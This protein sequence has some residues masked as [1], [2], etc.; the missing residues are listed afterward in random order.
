MFARVVF[1]YHITYGDKNFYYTNANKN[2][3]FNNTL[4]LAIPIQH[5]DM[6]N[7]SDEVT[8]AKVELNITNQCDYIANMLNQYD[9]YLTDIKIMRYY[10]TTGD[11]ETEFIGRLST[12][13]F[14]VKD[15]NCSFVNLLYDTQ[16]YAMRM[17]YQ[18]QCPF[19]L[20]G[21]QC[22]VNKFEHETRT[23]AELWT[24]IDDFH[25][26]FSGEIPA[27]TLG[28]IIVLP[29]KTPV[30]VR[31]VE[32]NVVTTS[33]PVYDSYMTNADNPYVL[34]YK[35]CDR[36]I[37]MC[38]EVFA[39]SENYGGFVKLPIDNPIKKNSL[40][41]GAETM[42]GSVLARYLKGQLK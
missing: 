33:R 29:N 16:R 14:S 19:A 3:L 4:Y 25:L 41:N 42:K 31:N 39:N 21:G 6:D 30:F 35:G 28:G 13:E 11:V 12:I 32:N 37:K 40:S 20:Y 27:Y 8:K 2:I 15:A 10:L 1:L 5:G 26:Q 7:N 34:I 23:D 24:R 22:K 18:R 17:I 36:S 38:N 9:A